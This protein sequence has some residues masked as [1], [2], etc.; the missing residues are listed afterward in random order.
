MNLSFRISSGKAAK[1]ELDFPSKD[2]LNYKMSYEYIHPI[3][4]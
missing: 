1:T 4:Y 3:T 2:K